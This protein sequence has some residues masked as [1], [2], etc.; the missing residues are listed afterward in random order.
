MA[1]M[2]LS[3]TFSTLLKEPALACFASYIASLVP[4][5]K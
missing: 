4:K 3:S 1:C 5:R 2:A